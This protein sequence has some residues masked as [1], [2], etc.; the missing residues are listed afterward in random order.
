MAS[1]SLLLFG[2]VS[3]RPVEA[4]VVE[5][6]KALRGNPDFQFLVDVLE[7]LPSLRQAVQKVLPHTSTLRE[8]EQV[9]QLKWLATMNLPED[10]ELS[11]VVSAPLTV[12]SQIVEYLRSSPTAGSAQFPYFENVQGFCIGFLSAAALAVSKDKED[13][14]H[15][16]SVAVRLAMCIGLIIDLDEESFSDPLDGSSSM[17]VWWKSFSMKGIVEKT[18]KDYPGVSLRISFPTFPP[19]S[20]VA[21]HR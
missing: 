7:E 17:V 16:A 5:L 10:Y 15:F 21:S 12:I 4:S 1:S 13:F 14:R 20:F 11:N 18:L 2:P 9:E 19:Y 6:R 8:H 3:P